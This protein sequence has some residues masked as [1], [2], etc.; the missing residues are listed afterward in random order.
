MKF[1]SKKG[2]Y[3]FDFFFKIKKTIT[4]ISVANID[5]NSRNNIFLQ[6]FYGNNSLKNIDLP[7][8]CTKKKPEKTLFA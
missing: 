5:K 6:M 2:Y 7:L 1:P 4:I 3:I 8:I